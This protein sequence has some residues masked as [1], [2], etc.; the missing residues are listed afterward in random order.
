MMTL[1]QKILKAVLMMRRLCSYHQTKEEQIEEQ[2]KWLVEDPTYADGLDDWIDS[3]RTEL[4]KTPEQRE[5]E[6]RQRSE[7]RAEREF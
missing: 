1:E 4:L 2:R 5:E 6:G 7:E 3:L